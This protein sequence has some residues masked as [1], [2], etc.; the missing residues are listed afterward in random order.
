MPSREIRTRHARGEP[1]SDGFKVW[2]FYN[3]YQGSVNFKFGVLYAKE[4]QS[5]DDEVFSNGTFCFFSDFI[6]DF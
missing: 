1:K 5:T 4:G 6:F 2:P 3:F